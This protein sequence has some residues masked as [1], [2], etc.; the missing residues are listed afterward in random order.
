MNQH[1]NKKNKKPSF[2]DK[3]MGFLGYVRKE[4][5]CTSEAEETK[6][7]LS[8]EAQRKAQEDN[9]VKNLDNKVKKLENENE[10]LKRE[11]SDLKKE[12]ATLRSQLSAVAP[13][14]SVS[15][16][17]STAVA[18]VP[19]KKQ[20]EVPEQQEAEY[21]ELPEGT[22]FYKGERVRNVKS[23]SVIEY[24]PQSGKGTFNL[25]CEID[26]LRQYQGV[27]KDAVEIDYNKLS[28]TH[29]KGYDIVES[30]T[31]ERSADGER[32]NIKTKVK[33]KLN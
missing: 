12:N 23:L 24:W 4:S 6:S 32:W 29:A 13:Q 16:H 2:L 30:G 9:K 28:F 7:E 27:L 11:N 20:Q 21:V 14:A 5:S 17:A 10:Q 19:R 3:I 15:P 26:N 8:I 22:Y 33:I 1:R 25:I 18:H 31:V